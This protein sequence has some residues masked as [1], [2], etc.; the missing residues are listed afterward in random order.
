MCWCF[1]TLSYGKR[2][3]R[4]P[5]SVLFRIAIYRLRAWHWRGL[6]VA[7]LDQLAA[8]A[9]MGAELGDGSQARQG[10][11]GMGQRQQ[12]AEAGGWG[13]SGAAW[14]FPCKEAERG[15][16]MGLIQDDMVQIA[17]TV[18]RLEEHYQITVNSTLFEWASVDKKLAA[19]AGV[20]AA[21]PPLLAAR[22]AARAAEALCRLSRREGLGGARALVP[23]WRFAMKQVSCQGP[24]PC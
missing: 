23:G 18:E 24:R 20:P 1:A 14:W 8:H 10:V 17:L 7:M 2:S 9:G 12:G 4:C 13:A 22:L 19:E 11:Q 21:P 3:V 6:Q 15:Q 5:H 16:I